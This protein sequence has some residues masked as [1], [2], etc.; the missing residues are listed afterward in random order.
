MSIRR[1]P[2]H[3]SA[4]LRRRGRVSLLSM[5]IAVVLVGCIGGAR[6]VTAIT[7]ANPTDHSAAV[8]VTGGNLSG[9]LSLGRTPPGS[10]RVFEEVLDVGAEWVFRFVHPEHSEEITMTREELAGNDWRVEVPARFGDRLNELG[11]APVDFID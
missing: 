9:W 7:V 1:M 2:A 4:R 3:P 11:V 8:E 5:W 10:E 6:H